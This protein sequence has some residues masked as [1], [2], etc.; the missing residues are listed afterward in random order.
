MFNIGDLLKG[1]LPQQAAPGAMPGTMPQQAP[2]PEPGGF[3]GAVSAASPLL[4][5][6]AA[7]MQS[8]DPYAHLGQ[9]IQQMNEQRDQKEADAMLQDLFGG[10]GLA[11]GM[12]GGQIAGAQGGFTGLGGNPSMSSMGAPE[13]TQQ[14]PLGDAATGQPFQI[15]PGSGQ[16]PQ[17]DK[18]FTLTEERY[19]LPAGY[20]ARTAQI[21]SGGDPNAR[22]PNSS[23]GGLFQ[24]IDSTARQYG[25]DKFDPAQ[26]TDGA[27][28]LAADSAQH[29]RGVLGR[30]PTAGELYLAH[31]QGAGG[32]AKLLSNPQARA[33]DLVGAD[34]VRLNGGDP[35]TMS[36]ADFAGKWLGKFGEGGG[37]S[38]MGGGGGAP[39]DRFANVPDE[40]L[41]QILQNAR[42][43]PAI[44]QIVGGVLQQ[45]LAGPAQ[46]DPYQ[47]EQLAL[48]REKF[49]FEQQQAAG[50]PSP[51]E[52][53]TVV[54]GRLVDL[55]AEGGPQT[56]I[57]GS[58]NAQSAIGK[59]RA[60]LD[61]GRI[62]QE[63][64]D[65]AMQNMAPPG[66]TIESDGA[67]GFR[68]TQG[69]NIVGRPLTEGQS[70]DNVYS[71]R[72]KGALA[73]VDT[74]GNALTSL[75]G[76]ALNAVPGGLGNYGQ[77]PEYQQGRNAGDE[78]LTAILR[79]DT[80]AAITKEE[81]AIYGRTYLPQPGDSPEVLARK[82]EARHRAVAALESGM[83]PEQI[84]ATENALARGGSPQSAP[85]TPPVQAAPPA[86]GAPAAGAVED[87]Y[88]FKG[89]NPADPNSWERM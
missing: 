51:D 9:G 70:K 69:T 14:L 55:Y 62:S 87:G 76:A 10:G 77:S 89:G 35:A 66:M 16:A 45:R 68:M 72:A 78:F 85:Q 4:L 73:D 27:A 6:L 84:I 7:G 25:I 22:N 58:E 50:G 57:A 17:L 88:R 75:P 83:S 49:A 46:M 61:A 31:Q 86:I 2:Q 15:Q 80:G 26:A 13:A 48:A 52:R 74:Y 1:F 38:S 60:D 18:V 19:G 5:S 29:L 42:V 41:F 21:E 23:A 24:F 30:E 8:G 39:A 36:A 64:F 43:D 37:M 54:G 53:Y 40:R 44:K 71:T 12:G 65:M 20:L 47:Q 11:G 63:Q 82:M 28:R 32:A 33:A 79:K 67:G 34:A 81:Q 3:K 56:V 59:L